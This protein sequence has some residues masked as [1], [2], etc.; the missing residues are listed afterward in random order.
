MLTSN[1]AATRG[2]SISAFSSRSRAGAAAH[3]GVG[4]D[5][6]DA[7][8][9]EHRR[10][11]PGR[12]Q[13]RVRTDRPSAPRRQRFS[14]TSCAPALSIS[15][16]ISR[17]PRAASASASARPMPEAPPV[18]SATCPCQSIMRIASLASWP[19]SPSASGGTPPS[20]RFRAAISPGSA[21]S[22]RH[23][24]KRSTAAAGRPPSC[25]R[26]RSAAAAAPRLPRRP[27]PPPW[28]APN[29]TPGPVSRGAA[30]PA[31]SNQRG[32]SSAR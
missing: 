15:A 18:T 7:A 1:I 32:H 3:A 27:T 8:G 10:V 31:A 6:V 13:R 23:R 16:M 30:R 21:N 4:G 24:W 22:C 12:R 11:R 29:R 20:R 5:E 28:R 2:V 14:A 25:R 17:A 9:R 19:L 26:Q